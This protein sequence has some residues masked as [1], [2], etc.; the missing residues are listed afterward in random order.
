MN[1]Y[2]IGFI[3]G[4]IQG[5][6]EFLPVSSSGHLVLAEKAGIGEVSVLNN[7]TLHF[8]TLVAVVIFYRKKILELLKKPKSKEMKF[9]L[10][11]SLPTAVMAGVIRFLLPDTTEYLPFFFITTSFILILP[12]I[13]KRKDDLMER[14]LVL[15]SVIV[16]I[17]QGI[18]CFNGIS[19]SGT[20]TSVMRI[21]GI[22]EEKCASNS[23]LLSIPIILGSCLVEILSSDGNFHIDGGTFIGMITAFIF[24][25]ISIKVFVTLLKKNRFYV[26]AVY[27]FFMGIVAFVYLYVVR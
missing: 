10:I 7:L 13:I 21:M 25:L 22:N 18:A 17:A 1:E 20:T 14:K 23:F 19:R 12:Y 8:A 3:L 4:L 15:T 9:I 16:G 11:A 5:L 27:T 2:L 24:G 6:T 26:F